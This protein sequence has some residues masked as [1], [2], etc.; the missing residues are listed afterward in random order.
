MD[1]IDARITK[2]KDITTLVDKKM[3]NRKF[4]YEKFIIRLEDNNPFQA[5]EFVKIIRK[6]DFDKLGDLINDVKNERDQLKD[7]VKNLH[8]MLDV[9]EKYI[10]KVDKPD[11]KSKGV[12]KSLI[13]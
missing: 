3:R 9:Q 12:L 13:G 11:K 4:E 7:Q 8:C 6:N 10:E 2:C 1:V 5:D